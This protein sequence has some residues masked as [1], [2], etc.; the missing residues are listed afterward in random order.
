MD[1]EIT[2][3]TE[4]MDFTRF[5][6]YCA[7]CTSPPFASAVSRHNGARHLRGFVFE[8]AGSS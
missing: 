4:M 6:R 2:R 8:S 1:A 7:C 3:V 5:L